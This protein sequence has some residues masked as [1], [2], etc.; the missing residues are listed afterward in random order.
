MARIVQKLPYKLLHSVGMV[1]VLSFPGA[2]KD[3]AGGNPWS[4]GR[5]IIYTG[6]L[7]SDAG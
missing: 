4:E 6:S 7:S 2:K 1:A 3:S 5:R